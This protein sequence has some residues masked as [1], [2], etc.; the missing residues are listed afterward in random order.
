MVKK[1][2][3]TL[4]VLSISFLCFNWLLGE[5]VVQYED[6]YTETSQGSGKADDLSLDT[7]R[8]LFVL[9]VSMLLA[10]LGAI[11]VWRKIPKK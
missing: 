7:L 4:L 3:I 10:L 1:I 11:F 2:V 9:P 8:I 6:W 5:V